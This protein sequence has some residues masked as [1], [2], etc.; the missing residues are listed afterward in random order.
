M[1]EELELKIQAWIDGEVSP[2]EGDR[3]AALIERDDQASQLVQELRATRRVLT[4]NEPQAAVPETREFYW[5]KI[6]NQIRREARVPAPLGWRRLLRWQRLI[7]SL[8]G[9]AALFA[10]VLFGI[11]QAAPKASFD[12]VSATVEGMEAITFHDQ[13]AGVTVVWLQDSQDGQDDQ[14]TQAVDP[15]PDDGEGSDLPM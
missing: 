9:A 4:A 2:S 12:E 13:T 7:P 6:Q 15:M 8:T 3:L 5:T 10:V 11:R 1:N 14:A